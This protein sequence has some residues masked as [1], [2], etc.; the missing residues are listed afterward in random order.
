MKRERE[1]RLPLCLVCAAA[2]AG[3]ADRAA[4]AADKEVARDARSCKKS[5]SKFTTELRNPKGRKAWVYRVVGSRGEAV[6]AAERDRAQA[7][8]ELGGGGGRREQVERHGG[9]AVCWEAAAAH[10][11]KTGGKAGGEGTARTGKERLPLKA[12]EQVDLEIQRC[13]N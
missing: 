2:T 8:D 12:F 13:L 1:G 7:R 3:P 4:A 11:G 9:G 6:A 10:R 5:S